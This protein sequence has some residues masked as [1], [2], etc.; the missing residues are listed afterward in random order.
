MFNVTDE[1]Q[2][3]EYGYK[4]LNKRESNHRLSVVE[5]PGKV[6]N[7]GPNITTV[8]WKNNKQSNYLN[9]EI[10]IFNNY[11]ELDKNIYD[12]FISLDKIEKKINKSNK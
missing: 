6:I 7:S 12:L 8:I 5:E 1:V 4:S 3:S 11:T 10:E 2:V 9:D